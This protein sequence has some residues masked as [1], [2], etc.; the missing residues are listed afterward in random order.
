MQVKF[1]VQASVTPSTEGKA[2]ARGSIPGTLVVRVADTCFPSENWVDLVIPVLGWW[3]ENTMR[4]VLPD[5]DVKNVF[6]DG[7]YAFHM[8]RCVGSDDVLLTF[9]ENGRIVSQLYTVSYRRCLASLRGAAKTV[10]GQ[11]RARGLGNHPDVST[12]ETRLEHLLR[13]E[14]DIRAHGLP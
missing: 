3:L 10:L 4:L 12:L 7:P 14:S 2:A 5:S 1:Q 9:S 13:L 6:M 8:R 11:V